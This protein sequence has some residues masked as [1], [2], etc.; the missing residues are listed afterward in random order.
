MDTGRTDEITVGD[1]YEASDGG[2]FMTVV[3]AGT[4]PRVYKLLCIKKGIDVDRVG[5]VYTHIT[6]GWKKVGHF[7]GI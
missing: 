3:M 7:D 2:L 1:I 6:T 5:S 4:E